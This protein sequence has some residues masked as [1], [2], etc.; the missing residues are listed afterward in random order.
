MHV[1]NDR[2]VMIV[3]LEQGFAQAVTSDRLSTIVDNVY[4]S[5]SDNR[6]TVKH[7]GVYDVVNLF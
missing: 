1:E 6:E 4:A 3:A 7:P 5:T 2:Q